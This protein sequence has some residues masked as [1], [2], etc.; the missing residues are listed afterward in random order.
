MH[1]R[2]KQQSLIQAPIAEGFAHASCIRLA[3][4]APVKSAIFPDR[5]L[6]RGRRGGAWRTALIRKRP[7]RDRQHSGPALAS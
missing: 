4:L 3:F 5:L 7:L 2:R 1:P 6:V